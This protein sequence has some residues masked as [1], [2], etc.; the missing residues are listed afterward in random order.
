VNAKEKEK[1]GKPTEGFKA[2]IPP[3]L[4]IELLF[5][6]NAGDSTANSG[7]SCGVF[8]T[9]SVTK[10][11]PGW[12]GTVPTNGG[13]SALDWGATPS[14]G[15]VDLGGGAGIEHLKNLRSFTITGWVNC[16]TD[17]ETAGDKLVPAG[18]RLLSWLNHGKDGVE[19]IHR[20][21]GSL[22]LG[23]NQWADASVATSDPGQVPIIEDKPKDAAAAERGNWRFFAV[24]YDSG[25]N[26]GHVKFYFG[27][28]NAD[29]KL[30]RAVDCDRGPV[31]P[32][33][34]PCLSIGNVATVSR[35]MAPD[36]HS[37][38]GVLDEI[39][40]FGSTLDGSGALDLPE[41]IKVQNRTA[42]TP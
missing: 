14:T 39:R 37:F 20:A 9:A 6:E 38:R 31:G 41:L 10:G 13:P 2:G 4:I 36:K 5:K 33:G 19:L 29:P 42:P 27:T 11:K 35:P 21:N 7:T 12:T 17:K 40:I 1:A 32:K 16:K 30:N 15:A 22:Q 3:P 26:A 34:A 18:N 24:T 28:L 8:A 25:T 23:I